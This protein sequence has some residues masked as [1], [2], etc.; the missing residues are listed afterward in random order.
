MYKVEYTHTAAKSLR[1]LSREVATRIVAAIM[2]LSNSPYEMPGVK[3]LSGR[4]GYRLRVGDWRILYSIHN[5]ILT[6]LILDIGSRGE[7]YK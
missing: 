6:I 5:D 3:K 2:E 4:D 1:K 7:V